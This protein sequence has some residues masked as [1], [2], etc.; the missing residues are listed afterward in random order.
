MLTS[1]SSNKGGTEENLKNSSEDKKTIKI[2]CMQITEPIIEYLAEGLEK[3]GYTVEPV[4]FDGNHLPATALKD[5]SV[6][7]VILNHLVWLNI[8]NQ[9]NDCNLV[10]PEPYM[11]Y[12]RNAMYSSKYEKVEDIPDGATIAVPGDPANLDRSLKIL[13]EL[14][15]IKLGEKTGELY[16]K[17]DIENNIKNIEILETEITATTRSINDV[18]AIISGANS[19]KDAGHDHTK[20][21]YDDPTNK[22]YPLGII[23]RDED[24]DLDWVKKVLEYQQSEEFK[25]K[26]NDRYD[27]TYVLFEE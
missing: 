15:F 22:D 20:Y 2:G 12:F 3:D 9:E 14:N 7:G 19:V 6:D 10:M 16:N 17:A 23:V 26:F 8:F 5:G 13:E 11:Y 21:L 1:C 18:D 24:S 27:Y 4:V 25:T